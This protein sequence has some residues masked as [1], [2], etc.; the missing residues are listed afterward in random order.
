[1]R[2]FSFAILVLLLAEASIVGQGSPTPLRDGQQVKLTGQ[3]TMEPAGRLQFVTVKT[4]AAYAPVFKGESGG[5]DSQGESLHAVGLAGYS[6]YALLY[7]HR[8]QLVTVTGKMQTDNET[9]YFWHG[10]RLALTSLRLADGTD[11]LH[12]HQPPRD[13]LAADTGSYEATVML[14]ADLAAPWVYSAHGEPTREGHFLSCSSNGGGDVVNCYCAQGF[15]AQQVESMR[16][17]VHQKGDVVLG[18]MA[19]VVIGE[20]AVAPAVRITVTCSR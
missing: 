1:M 5:K 12:P 15:H 20:D 9:P 16:K 11:L 14:P 6:D 4:A 8:G 7:A 2:C 13:F 17:G 10:T 19:Q 3:L 18:G